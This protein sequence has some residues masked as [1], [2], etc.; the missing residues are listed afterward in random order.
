M[1]PVKRI[2]LI[3]TTECLVGQVNREIGQ[4]APNKH[5]LVGFQVQL[6]GNRVIYPSILGAPESGKVGLTGVVRSQQNRVVFGNE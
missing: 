5:W 6:D 2:R 1:E 4:R 3:T